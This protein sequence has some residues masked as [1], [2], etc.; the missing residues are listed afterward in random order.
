MLVLFETP[1][2]YAVFKLMDE[3]KL[4]KS[5]SLY[6]DFE[7]IDK[8]RNVVKLKQF[9]K[10]EDTTEALSAATAAVEGKMSKSLK[11]LLKK[12]IAEDAHEKLAVADAKLG[13]SIQEKLDLSCVYDSKIGEL[14][15]C[16]R[17]QISGLISG[18]PD[19]EMAAME[20]GLAHSL[21]RYKLKFSPDKI[22]T[23]IVQAVSLLDDLDKELNN[24]IMRCREW[25]GWHFPELGKIITDNLA[26]V[27]TVELMGTR[28][29]AKSIDLSDVL[30]EE[31]E[32][33]VKEAAEISMG[34]EISGEDIINIKHLCQQVVEIQEYRGQLYEYLK[35]RMMA[36]AP[37]L[38][39]LVGEL[40]G[41]RLIAH[42]GT[43]MNLAKHPAST[44]QILG[45]EKALFKALKTKHDTPKYGLIYHAQLVG[46][47]GTKLKGKVSRMLAAKASLACRVDALGEE[48][49]TDL[50]IEHRAKV[51]SRIRQ[52]EGGEITKISATAKQS[53]KFDKYESKSEVLEYKAAAD[54]TLKR[55]AE[56]DG[57]E[58]PDV[59]KIKVEDIEAEGSKKKKKKK[60]KQKEDEIEADVAVAASPEKKKK[61]K[62]KDSGAGDVADST[63]DTSVMDTSVAENGEKKKKK[64]KKKDGD[65]E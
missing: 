6:E 33:K 37:N 51:E 48:T 43:L 50:G 60:D 22:D 16:I 47:S 4:A 20:L 35:N 25:Y 5:D 62:D 39:V 65:G 19:K 44:V 59:K 52:L 24:Y 17:S 9:Q 13:G 18:L 64:K 46:Q 3:G 12:V 30:P 45:A 49:N 23:M 28:E 8:A 40:V 2:G 57:E 34:T 54:V 56:D 14:M 11:K 15:R 27:R 1:A 26:F 42:A 21:S 53:A 61:K 29:N 41:A 32:E 10:F 55:K 38:T 31:V 36:I 58:K 63:L 7:S